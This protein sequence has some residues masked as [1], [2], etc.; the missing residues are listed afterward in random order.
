MN[1]F[2]KNL[3]A[4][5]ERCGL[6]RQELAEAAGVNSTSVYR[7]ETGRREPRFQEALR[8]AEALNTT[9]EELAKT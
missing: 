3:K 9:L 5:R 7:Y 6:T 8:L 1:T 4:V 2:G